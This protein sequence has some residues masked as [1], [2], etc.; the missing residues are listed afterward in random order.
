MSLWTSVIFETYKQ[1]HRHKVRGARAHE[2]RSS[3]PTPSCSDSRRGRAPRRGDVDRRRHEGARGIDRGARARLFATLDAERR[4]NDRR[5]RVSASTRCAVAWRARR[6]SSTTPEDARP[7]T[8]RPANVRATTKEKRRRRRGARSSPLL[9]PP[10]NAFAT[11]SARVVRRAVARVR[12]PRRG[13]WCSSDRRDLRAPRRR[14]DR[15]LQVREPWT[16]RVAATLALEGRVHRALGADQGDRRCRSRR[17]SPS[18]WRPPAQRAVR[19]REGR[20]HGL[21]RGLGRR[22]S[23]W[24]CRSRKRRRGRAVASAAVGVHWTPWVRRGDPGRGSDPT[25]R[26]TLLATLVPASVSAPPC[27][28]SWSR[29]AQS[30]KLTALCW[31]TPRGTRR[32]RTPVRVQGQGVRMPTDVRASTSRLRRSMSGTRFRCS[33]G[34]TCERLARGRLEGDRDRS[35]VARGVGRRLRRV[36]LRVA[37]TSSGFCWSPGP[38]H[39]A[40]TL[41]HDRRSSGSAAIVQATSAVTRPTSTDATEGGPVP[42]PVV[43]D[44]T[45]SL[46]TSIAWPFAARRRSSTTARRSRRRRATSA[47]SRCRR[48]RRPR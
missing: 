48:R 25:G 39:V 36:L 5:G 24:R 26:G 21:V 46:Q 37:P 18:W 20:A 38:P 42:G 12:P 34:V 44:A 22:R 11:R 19:D 32:R 9:G 7:W 13:R 3:P 1:Q 43:T 15:D 35:A 17:R 16:A 4:R 45:V 41:E 8:W 29:S 47:S 27:V 33:S 31:S 23:R 40:P 2:R 30:V 14:R 10:R 6:S 28:G